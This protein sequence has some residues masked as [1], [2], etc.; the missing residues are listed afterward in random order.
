MEENNSLDN[1]G[2]SQSDLQ[3]LLAV[4]KANKEAR[5]RAGEVEKT[6]KVD[7]SEYLR[8]L[9]EERAKDAYLLTNIR[10]K[11]A[12]DASKEWAAKVGP[13]FSHAETQTPQI[14]ER[15]ERHRKKQGLHKT[16][17][18]FY[19]NQYGRGKTWAA[20]SYL[21]ALVKEGII[22]PG[23]IFFGTESATISRIANSGFNRS[24]EMLEMKRESH[25]IF[26]IDDVGQGYFFKKEHREEVWYELIDHIYTKR[27]TLILTTNL[28]FT[29]NNGLGNW[30]GGRGWDRLRTLVGNDG[31]LELRGVN[32]RDAIF[33]ENEEAYHTGKKRK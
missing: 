21:N 7:G 3:S 22:L 16:S 2:L 9:E 18:M 24:E 13:T 11:K 4:M 12:N 20:Y 23:Q 27:L 10:K 33:Q 5:L 8:R 15:V 1:N 29:E 32:K 31:A 14:L 6:K 17:I 28:T 30:V 26:F 19:G 25:K